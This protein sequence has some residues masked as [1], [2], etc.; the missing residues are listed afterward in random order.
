M[1]SKDEVDY[2]NKIPGDKKV[3]THPFNPQ[4]TITAERIIELI[5]NM[6]P[7][8][9][10]KHMGASALKISGQNDLDIYA[11]SNP[12]DFDRYLPGLIKILG[13]PL[14]VHDTF[15]EWGFSKNG[16]NVQF[17]L[18]QK[19]SPTMQKQIEV[20][21]T[22]KN[23]PKLL[24]DY[25]NL[26]NSLNG[27][28]FK[29]YQESKYRFYNR[30]L[31]PHKILDNKIKAILFDMVGVL[32]FK[33]S[34][35]TPKSKDELNT[36]EIEKLYNHIDDKKLINDIKENLRLTDLEIEKAAKI[37]PERFERFNELWKELPKL[38]TRYKMAV[39]NNGNAIAKKYWDKKFGF[40]DFDIFINSAIEGIKKPDPAIY[41]LTCNRLGV[42]PHDC[43]FMDDT[44]EN[45]ETANKLGMETIWWDKNKNKKELL[46][47]FID[48]YRA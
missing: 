44:L 29:E 15:I 5:K 47:E 10:V 30:I 33:K 31:H 35:Y 4:A 28:S 39:I 42:N 38:K 13:K 3:F 23:D 46:A 8:L 12:I 27:K 17:Y 40:K 43:L 24:K 45:I 25:E 18:T 11:F 36:E 48:K 26:K 6:Y 1:L 9:E 37:M 14:H 34:N 2:L 32:V 22:L 16:F 7:A 20:F 41:L 19:D 21:E